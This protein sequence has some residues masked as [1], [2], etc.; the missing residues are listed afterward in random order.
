MLFVQANLCLLNQFKSQS[1]AA[2]QKNRPFSATKVPLR[3]IFP[4][5]E[6]DSSKVKEE[7]ESNRTLDSSSTTLLDWTGFLSAYQ[8]SIRQMANMKVLFFRSERICL[9][10]G[11]WM[12]F[13]FVEI[14]V[15]I[16]VWLWF[17]SFLVHFSTPHHY[18]LVSGSTESCAMLSYKASIL[19]ETVLYDNLGFIFWPSV[20]LVMITLNSQSN[21]WALGTQRLL[22][23]QKK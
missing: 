21:C 5:T 17:P 15:S 4:Y 2:V 16:E 1:K 8:V 12:L 6:T 13:R 7:A 11:F 23:Q 3:S 19:K 18:F 20:L 14:L 9:C 10:T 22:Q